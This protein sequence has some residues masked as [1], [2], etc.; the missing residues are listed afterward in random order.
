MR[1]W[2]KI[3]GKRLLALANFN[4]PRNL[5]GQSIRVPVRCGIKVGIT[6]EKWMSDLFRHIFKYT[7]DSFLD[8]GVNLGQTLIKAKTVDPARKYIGIEPNPS[9]VFYLRELIRVNGW[10][11]VMIVPV[12]IYTH[13]CLLNL[14]GRNDTDGSSTIIDDFKPASSAGETTQTLVPLFSF[15]TLQK[16]IPETKIGLVKIDVEGGELEVMQNLSSRLMKDRP[17][18]IIE[19]WNNDGDPA[20]I[21]RSSA[22]KTLIEELEYRVLSWDISDDKHR[23]VNFREA[24]L[25]EHEGTDNYL[26][27]P[28]EKQDEML[29]RLRQS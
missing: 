12:G 3:T 4:I 2:L 22:L 21:A 19:V 6:G 26:L 5:N 16:S 28:A 15:S 23:A 29:A 27:L 7:D 1:K 18:V 20:K 13:E 10:S 14:T 17:L 25:G 24:T 9:C 8:I 11:D